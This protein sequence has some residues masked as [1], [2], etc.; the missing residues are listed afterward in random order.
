MPVREAVPG[1]ELAIQAL[2]SAMHRESVYASVKFEQH[3]LA[4]FLKHARE[5]PT[6]CILVYE[7]AEG[8]I[9]GV[10]IG[11]VNSYFFSSELGAW[12]MLF[13]VRP[14]RR[15]SL[16]AVRLWQAFRAWTK[17]AGAKTIWPGISTG[18]AAD[19]TARFYRGLGLSE[20]GYVFFGRLDR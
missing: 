12:D 16:V 15:G 9:D 20:V 11:Y 18:V 3:R 13:Y 4:A 7:N 6:H 14:S 10:Y 2:I 5:D 17:S 19:R 1:D 8:V